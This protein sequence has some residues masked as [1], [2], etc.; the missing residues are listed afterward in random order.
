MKSP[1]NDSVSP[2]NIYIDTSALRGMSF[3]K[4]VASLLALSN[5]GKIRLHISEATLKV[6]PWLQ[7]DNP[8]IKKFAQNYI[9][10]L[11][12]QL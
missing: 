10:R 9:N 12:Y 11:E 6:Q 8:M 5:S 7:D 3:N 4:D 1:M 2:Q